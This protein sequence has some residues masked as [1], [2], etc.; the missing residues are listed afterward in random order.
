[1]RVIYNFYKEIDGMKVYKALLNDKY[2][3]DFKEDGQITSIHF[4]FD[5]NGDLIVD[6]VY[7]NMRNYKTYRHIRKYAENQTLINVMMQLKRI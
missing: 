4:Y 5:F 6:N 2:S 1:M 3:L 7:K